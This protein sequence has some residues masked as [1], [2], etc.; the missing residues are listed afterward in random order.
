MDRGMKARRLMGLE[1]TKQM[2][3]LVRSRK[4]PRPGS[5]KFKE[6]EGS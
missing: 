2:I 1:T 4:Q 3:D 5:K 6:E